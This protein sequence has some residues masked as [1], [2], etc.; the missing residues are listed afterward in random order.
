MLLVPGGAHDGAGAARLI[1]KR[2]LHR[3]DKTTS[4]AQGSRRC[5]RGFC[6]HAAAAATC[7]LVAIFP[8]TIKRVPVLPS[9]DHV[10]I[11]GA[12]ALQF[13]TSAGMSYAPIRRQR[14]TSL[15]G[16]LQLPVLRRLDQL[17]GS[18]SKQ[19]LIAA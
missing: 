14:S 7:T 19:T 11:A 3:K 2:V 16:L 12:N 9:P 8:S 1:I 4:E 13:E 5:L 6:C 10:V 17:E 18:Y 15:Q